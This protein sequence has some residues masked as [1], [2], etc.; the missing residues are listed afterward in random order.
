MRLAG[1]GT[2]RS[3]PGQVQ[4]IVREA[5]L[6][7][8]YRAID[9]AWLYGNENEVGNG[10]HQALEQGEGRIKRE[11]LFIT[12]KLWNQVRTE[13]AFSLSLSHIGLFLSSS[14]TFPKMSNG[15]VGI[16]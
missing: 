16:V 15:L 7:H 3:E 12:T 6:K 1:L 8:G 2:W 13:D 14:T 9:G 5:I 10:I 4:S 11:D